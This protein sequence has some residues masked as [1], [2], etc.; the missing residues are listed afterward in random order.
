MTSAKLKRLSYEV[1]VMDLNFD[2]IRISDIKS[3]KEFFQTVKSILC[4]YR[5]SETYALDFNWDENKRVKYEVVN[6]DIEFY[7]PKNGEI[8]IFQM[9]IAKDGNIEFELDPKLG[10]IKFHTSDVGGRTI[11]DKITQ[12]GVR[13]NFDFEDFGSSNEE[14]LIYVAKFDDGSIL[15]DSVD[16]YFF[17][18]E[19][20]E[21]Q[22]HEE[23]DMTLSEITNE[24]Y[25]AIFNR[26]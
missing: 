20:D 11:L 12:N 8:Q 17:Y 18:S 16:A 26:K 7:K 4:Q 22:V 21:N 25:E 24:W 15:E 9:N 23:Y 5:N 19:D 13:I 3:S 6:E 2:S 10:A 14:L 1:C